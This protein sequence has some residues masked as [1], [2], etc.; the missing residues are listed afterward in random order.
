[1]F[2]IKFAIYYLHSKKRMLRS[3]S[4]ADALSLAS[5]NLPCSSQQGQEN[6]LFKSLG[7]HPP[8]ARVYGGHG[9]AVEYQNRAMLY[10]NKEKRRVRLGW[11]LSNPR[12]EHKGTFSGVLDNECGGT[13]LQGCMEGFLPETMGKRSRSLW[14]SLS[15]QLVTQ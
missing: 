3:S 6:K 5:K 9:D 14:K 8:T 1:M 15:F 7:I 12:C 13:G 11:E 2:N 4:K 10:I